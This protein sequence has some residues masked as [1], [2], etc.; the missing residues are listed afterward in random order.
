MAFGPD[1]DASDG[2]REGSSD[3]Q[4]QPVGP[5]DRRIFVHRD[6]QE[7]QGPLAV[8]RRGL[9]TKRTH[10]RVGQGL[11]REVR[12]GLDPRP[13]LGLDLPE[14][15]QGRVETSIRIGL[16]PPCQARLLR[17]VELGSGRCFAAVLLDSIEVERA[18]VGH[19]FGDLV[20]DQLQ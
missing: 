17:I 16:V 4:G 20:V 10:S 2:R 11:G 7:G 18:F 6:V 14:L 15:L 12:R 5:S 8:G 19:Q 9:R 1:P 3:A 13:S